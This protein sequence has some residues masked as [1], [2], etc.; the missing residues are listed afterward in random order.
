MGLRDKIGYPAHNNKRFKSVPVASA[1][2]IE[3]VRDVLLCI[4]RSRDGR[5][6]LNVVYCALIDGWLVG[7]ECCNSELYKHV[8]TPLRRIFKNAL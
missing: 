6:A 7:F 5:L 2:G 4:H 1:Y 3:I 8:S